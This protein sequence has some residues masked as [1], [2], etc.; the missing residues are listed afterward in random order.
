MSA[1]PISDRRAALEVDGGAAMKS[2]ARVIKD[3]APIQTALTALAEREREKPDPVAAAA[4]LDKIAARA[5]DVHTNCASQMIA[6]RRTIVQCEAAFAYQQL[7]LDGGALPKALGD[8]DDTDKAADGDGL[9][10]ESASEQLNFMRGDPTRERND[11]DR[12]RLRDPCHAARRYAPSA[13]NGPHRSTVA[14]EHIVEHLAVTGRTALAAEV[15][16]RYGLP[17]WRFPPRSAHSTATDTASVETW[18]D[19]QRAGWSPEAVRFVVH[20]LQRDPIED[21]AV[22][23]IARWLETSDIGVEGCDMAGEVKFTVLQ[24]RV[25]Q[26]LHRRAR[27]DIATDVGAM[28]FVT[29]HIL[30]FSADFADVVQQVV[31]VVSPPAHQQLIGERSP[32]RARRVVDGFTFRRVANRV[33]NIGRIMELGLGKRATPPP[34]W[35]SLSRALVSAALSCSAE[36]VKEVCSGEAAPSGGIDAV[37]VETLLGVLEC[38]GSDGHPESASTTAEALFDH[39]PRR[40]HVK[41]HSELTCG[42]T[43]RPMHSHSDDPLDAPMAFPNGT[44]VSKRA[45]LTSCLVRPT[46]LSMGSASAPAA[47]VGNSG[48]EVAA[49]DAVE[50]DCE[51]EK[52]DEE[53]EESDDGEEEEGAQSSDMSPPVILRRRHGGDADSAADVLLFKCP[54]TG[55]V[56]RESQLRRLFIM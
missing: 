32:G 12:H 30:G 7:L 34:V 55:E 28:A 13:V 8:A 16:A 15:A 5:R 50:S 40:L 10:D 17:E 2:L 4:S 43:N 53:E 25:A 49:D 27:G 1:V 6:F 47:S 52:A 3:F 44:I 18:E 26:L 51:E 14:V 45:L 11:R 22:E 46:P 23:C 20:H 35:T 56:F 21:E 41:R 24:L 38:V 9:K 29:Q 42:V 48:D 54:R 33:R 36:F 37:V 39:L 31:R 19:A